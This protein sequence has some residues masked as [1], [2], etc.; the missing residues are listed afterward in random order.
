MTAN[1]GSPYLSSGDLESL[2]DAAGTPRMGASVLDIAARK[3]GIDEVFAY[4]GGATAHPM[5]LASSGTGGASSARALAY[6]N[7]F[8]SFDPVVKMVAANADREGTLVRRVAASEIRQSDY[9]Q[10]CFEKPLFSEKWSFARWRGDRFYVLS[11][12]RRSDRGQA[13][14]EALATLADMALPVLRKHGE[15]I[16]PEVEAPLLDRLLEGLQ[17][18][19]P[20][21]TERERAVCARTL[22]GMTAEAIALDLGVKPSTVLTYRRRAYERF[23]I[24]SAN[25]LM[26][27]LIA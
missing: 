22:A 13:D 16:A 6:T 23:G 12:Y 3:A 27:R 25:Q 5:L 19:Y 9:R 7:Q 8:H 1:G 20:A 24:S 18:H 10:Q 4:C 2:I 17:T 26:A 11:F 15:L 21:L 14:G